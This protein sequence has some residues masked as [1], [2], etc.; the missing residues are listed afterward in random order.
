[1]QMLDLASLAEG[2]PGLRGIFLSAMPDCLL[3]DSYLPHHDPWPSEELA[4]L[5]GDLLVKHRQ[6]LQLLQTWSPEI[7]VTIE[8]SDFTLILREIRSDFV[9]GFVFEPT[10]PFGMI[11]LFSKRLQ[12]TL[13][14]QLASLQPEPSASADSRAARI[15]DFLQRYAPDPHTSL[16]RLALKTGIPLENLEQPSSLAPAHLHKVEEAVCDILGIDQLQL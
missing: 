11:R 1:M 2:V 7:Q 4:S 3:L 14:Q 8:S 15:L 6:T 12:D 9:A 10:S 5:F 13:A 16:M